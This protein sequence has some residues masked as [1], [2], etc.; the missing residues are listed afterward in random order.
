MTE[1]QREAFR[2]DAGDELRAELFYEGRVAPCTLENLSAGGARLVS[3]LQMDPATQCTLGVR[4]GKRAHAP[5][6]RYVSFLL[7]VLDATPAADGTSYRLRSLTAP[8]TPEY[9]EAAKLVFEMQRQR[10]GAASGA[11]EASPMATDEQRRQQLRTPKRRRFSKGSL[12]P[13]QGD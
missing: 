8:G 2:L 10:L 12:R 9:E 4:L 5:G 6:V 3:S 1:D 11:D 13:G 7:E